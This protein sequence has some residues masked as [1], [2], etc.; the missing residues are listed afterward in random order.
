M[1]WTLGHVIAHRTASSKEHAFIAVELARGVSR[2]SWSRPETEWTTVR[3]LQPDRPVGNAVSRFMVGREHDDSY[4]SQLAATVRQARAAR[5][6][7]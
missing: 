5:K 6:S 4:L 2:P 1:P 3:S 7:A